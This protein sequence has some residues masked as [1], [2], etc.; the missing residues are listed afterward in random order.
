MEIQSLPE[1]IAKLPHWRV[2][3]RPSTY[4]KLISDPQVAFDLVRKSVVRRRGWDYPYVS[5][6]HAEQIREKEYVA[7]GCDW[8]DL[9]EYWRLYYSGQF[10]HLF[11][12]R[13][14]VIYDTQG[15]IDITNTLYNIAEVIEFA[16]RLSEKGIY[17]DS[18][19]ISIQIKNVKDFRLWE[20]DRFWRGNFLNYLSTSN[21]IEK[22]IEVDARD[23]PG[24]VTNLTLDTTIYVF[25]MFCWDNPPRDNLKNDLEKFL[26]GR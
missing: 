10:I 9:I 17:Q 6:E 24:K 26:V 1:K 8:N 16:A 7:S 20:K 14:N 11:F 5:D 21:I 12:L 3:Y 13:E 15:F 25:K 4:K 23:L 18:L 19:Q 2:T 22:I